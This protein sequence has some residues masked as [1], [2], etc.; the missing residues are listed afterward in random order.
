[1]APTDPRLEDRLRAK[2]P[3]LAPP[4]PE[5][6]HSRGF[7][8]LCGSLLCPGLGHIFGGW[9]NLGATCFIVMWVMAASV[10]V[11]LTVPR[12]FPYL[13]ILAPVSIVLH[14]SQC[15]SA[16]RCCRNSTGKMLGDRGTRYGAAFLCVT[17]AIAW[18][19]SATIYLRDN[20]AEIG[21]CPTSSMAPTIVPND[22]FLVVRNYP[23]GRWDVVSI[24]SPLKDTPPQLCKRV[25][26]IPDDELEITGNGLL[27]DGQLTT[28]PPG[29]D[30]FIPV[31]KWNELMPAS[32][33]SNAAMGCWGKP[34]HLA[35]DEYFLL[36]DNSPNSDDSR[37]FPAIEGH[38]P[39]AVPPDQIV[40]R[41][42]LVLWPPAHWRKFF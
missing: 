5:R 7:L 32:D 19:H 9:L 40:G 21:F 26:G 35:S 11:T 13:I 30:R 10:I 4:P 39:G 27:I 34:I 41:V 22:Y 31:D 20:I 36:G 16:S 3:K 38:Q 8:G 24:Y 15:I 2:L 28:L 42:M 23:F 14:F 6:D 1:M 29:V 17:A 37:F 25:V 18:Q 33:P 12:Y